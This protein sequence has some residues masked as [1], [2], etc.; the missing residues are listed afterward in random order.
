MKPP[1]APFLVVVMFAG[2]AAI[3]AQQISLPP[4]NRVVDESS[5]KGFPSS[6]MFWESAQLAHIGTDTFRL[7]AVPP[8]PFTSLAVAWNVEGDAIPPEA[9]SLT[10]TS[11]SASGRWSIPVPLESETSPDENPSGLYWS[12]L[13]MTPGGALNEDAE[14]TLSCPPGVR[15]TTLQVMTAGILPEPT[16]TTLFTPAERSLRNA[17]PARPAIIPRSAWW[18][19]LPPD[20]LNP[21][22]GP[23][24]I[25]ISHAVV[26]H[27][28]GANNPPDPPQEV[29]SIWNLHVYGNGWSDIGYNFLIDQYG[30][31]YQGRYNPWLDSTEVQG[32]HATSAN[33]KSVGIS[34]LGNFSLAAGGIPDPRAIKSLEDLIAWRFGQRNLDPLESASIPTNLGGPRVLPRICGHRDV[35]NTECP[36]GN[37]YGL[38]PTVQTDVSTL[39]TTTSA[40]IDALPLSAQLDQNYPNPFNPS[41]SVSFALPRRSAVRLTVVDM[42]GRT[43]ETL[44]EAVLDAGVHRATWTATTQA[45][46]VYILRLDAEGQRLARRML[47]LR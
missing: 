28:A 17:G 14:I 16:T 42:L 19:S 21:L 8:T 46:G 10:V 26:H 3:M 47:L 20:S 39:I 23:I 44:K 43:V 5:A 1:T 29:R 7:Q 37:L 40:S 27:T 30:N 38:L 35:G 36:G 2:P 41:T 11:R 12:G 9:F 24:L 34:I 22:F 4:P 32:A 15:L 13:Y 45:G 31:I 18:G 33:V 6:R 25:S